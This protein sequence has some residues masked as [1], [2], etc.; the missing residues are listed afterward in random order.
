MQSSK[1]ASIRPAA[2]NK[3]NENLG[4][5]KALRGNRRKRGHHSLDSVFARA[6]AGQGGHVKNVSNREWPRPC[7]ASK[8]RYKEVGPGISVPN[9]GRRSVLGKPWVWQLSGSA[10]QK[11]KGQ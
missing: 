2:E 4:R 6:A 11:K 8:L 9:H 7:F 3:R 10:G 5:R 1:A